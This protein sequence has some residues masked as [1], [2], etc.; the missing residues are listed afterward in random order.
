MGEGWGEGIIGLILMV[1]L[2]S[3]VGHRCRDAVCCTRRAKRCR[4]RVSG[5]LSAV[6]VLAKWA[7]ARQRRPTTLSRYPSP[8]TSACAKQAPFSDCATDGAW[9]FSASFVDFSHLSRIG[10][11]AALNDPTGRGRRTPSSSHFRRGSRQGP[12]KAGTPND[13]GR[14]FWCLESRL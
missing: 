12:A 9:C 7:A 2:I 14:D 8:T 10:A 4:R 5:Q 3:V 13:I 6:P 1:N 11:V